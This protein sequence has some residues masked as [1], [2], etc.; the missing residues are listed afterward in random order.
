MVEL[1]GRLVVLGRPGLAAVQR[2]ARAAVVGVDQP[3]GLVGVDPQGVVVAMGG[4]NEVEALAAVGGAQHAGV[5]RIDGVDRLGVGVDLGEVP[6]PLADA[7]VL[8]HPHPVATRVVGAVQAAV[9]RL[10]HGVDAVG[11]G[12]GDGHVDA[13]EDPCR[14]ALALQFAPGEAAVGRAEQPAAR[15]AAGEIPGLA[16]HLPQGG[17]DDLRVVRVEGDVDGAGVLVAVEHLGP[18]LAAVGGAEHAAFGVGPEGV[19]D[20]GDQHDVGIGRIDDDGADLAGVLQPDI[21]PGLA[22]VGR[23]VDPVAVADIAPQVALAAPDIDHVVVGRGDRHCADGGDGLLVEDGLPRAARVIGL[24]DAAG[25]SAEVEDVGLA[26]NAGD[27][28]RP[29]AAEGA[30]VAP[31]HGAERRL[32]NGRTRLSRSGRRQPQRHPQHQEAGGQQSGL[33]HGPAHLRTPHAI[34]FLDSSKSERQS[35]I[36]VAAERRLDA[37]LEHPRIVA[38]VAEI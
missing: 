6:G 13:A 15:P 33:Q 19:A 9:F 17:V 22:G 16:T 28:H 36:D 26:R 27:G 7:A 38:D 21:G 8:A 18:G 25:R 1:G 3:L 14:Q 37:V 4:R 32:R 12:L 2:H 29:A 35:R 31:V 23:L 5:E 11:V 10:D 24:P 20:G 30:D 34:I